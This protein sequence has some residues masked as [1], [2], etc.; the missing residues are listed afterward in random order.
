MT[1]SEKLACLELLICQGIST[2]IRR[3]HHMAGKVGAY[4]NEDDLLLADR[5]DEA[6]KADSVERLK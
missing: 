1:D 5:I 4:Q 2:L 3:V 6:L